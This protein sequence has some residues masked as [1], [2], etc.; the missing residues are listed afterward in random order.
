[1]PTKEYNWSDIKA[2]NRW[3]NYAYVLEADINAS[4]TR[5]M[6]ASQSAL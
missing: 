4:S 6:K 5:L 3:V 1:M 2:E